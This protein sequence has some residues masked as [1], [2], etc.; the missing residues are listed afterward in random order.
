[1]TK[2]KKDICPQCRKRMRREFEECP[3]C[4]G[5]EVYYCSNCGTM[6]DVKTGEEL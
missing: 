4:G 6:C 2:R 1:M 5:E 3:I